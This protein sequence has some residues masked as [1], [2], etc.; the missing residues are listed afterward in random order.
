MTSVTKLES[1]SYEK[2]EQPIMAKKNSVEPGSQ[3]IVTNIPLPVSSNPLVIDLPD[4]QK[5]V[6]GK[7]ESGAVIEVA[8]WRGTGRP[9]SRT[10]RL[11][12]GMT[13]Q[14]E[15]TSSS[16]DGATNTHS[17][18]SANYS[19]STPQ[20]SKYKASK[21][22]IS[23]IT[24]PWSKASLMAALHFPKTITSRLMAKSNELAPVETTTEL[25]INQ[26]LE[27]ISL[28]AKAK[29]EKSSAKKAAPKP[30]K[31]PS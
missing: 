3:P 25:N 22:G 12:L 2:G 23:K 19:S 7:M 24:I 10:N 1:N 20:G 27:E 13:T 14:S 17:S 4:G 21:L 9:D 18:P 8:T 28:E 30:K 15:S 16:P 31:Q 29:V 26:W 5:L 6:I 11:M